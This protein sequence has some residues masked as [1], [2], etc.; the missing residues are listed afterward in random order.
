MYRDTVMKA[1]R[2]NRL[3]HDVT[4]ELTYRCNL[5]CFYCYNDHDRKGKPLSLAQ[6]RVLLEDLARMQTLFLMLTGGEPMVHPHFFDIGNMTREL[7]FVVRIRS[8]GHLLTPRNIERLLREVEPYTVEV[9]LHGASAEV[10]DRQTRVPGSFDRLIGNLSHARAAGLRCATVVTPT[11]WNEHQIEAMIALGDELGAPLRFQGPVGPRSNG[12]R[13]PLS[14]QPS[15]ATWDRIEA[16]VAERRESIAAGP[17]CPAVEVS[18]DTDAEEMAACRVGLAGADIDPFGN[19]KA[20]MHLRDI[21]GNLHQQS[22]EEIWTRS[23]VF[24]QVRQ[25]AIA[26]A[27]G[28]NGERPRQFGAPVFCMAIDEM[29]G[30]KNE[31][32]VGS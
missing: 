2:A 30:E 26:A 32:C 6:Y 10:H 13:E 20:C 31:R 9:T 27:A 16:L 24:M 4:L 22:I 14:I 29:C 17:E 15:W 8:N 12:D 19:V 18:S 7:G 5:D 3:L 1:V 28:W 23:P 25:R 21:A 11:T